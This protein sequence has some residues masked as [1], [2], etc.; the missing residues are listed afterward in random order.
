MPTRRAWADGYFAQASADWAMFREVRLRADVPASYALHY[1]Q[2]ATEKLAKAYRFRNTTASAETLLTSHV[3]FDAFMRAFLQSQQVHRMY[4]S[5]TAQL[6]AIRRGCGQLA[7]LVEQLAPAVG[8]VARP[9]NAEYPWAQGEEVIV[10]VQ[11]SFPS[12]DLRRHPHA[13]AFLS[14]IQLAFEDYEAPQAP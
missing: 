11:Y 6:A 10:P 7:R 9:E 13:R 4:N 5:R 1:L 2:M 8:G 14:F 3:G 12:L